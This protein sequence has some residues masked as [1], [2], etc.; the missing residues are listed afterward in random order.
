MTKIAGYQGRVRI[1][2]ELGSMANLCTTRWQVSWKVD[3]IDVSCTEHGWV[4]ADQ[5]RGP[6]TPFTGHLPGITDIDISFDAF[7]ENDLGLFESPPY[8]K[9]GAY[10]YVDLFLHKTL[11]NHR[12]VFSSVLILDCTMDSEVRGVVKYSASGKVSG[13]QITY[14]YPRN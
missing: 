1:G 12:W 14:F 3:D 5:A 9:P 10:L 7:W 4:S 8:L 11:V 13:G 6:I 2:E